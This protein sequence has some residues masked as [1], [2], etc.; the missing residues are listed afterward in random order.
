MSASEIERP[1]SY[2]QEDVQQILQLAMV[3]RQ[4]TN[5]EKLSRQ[6]LLEIAAELEI[7]P[8]SLQLAEQDWLTERTLEKKRAAF[9]AYRRDKLKQKGIRYI[10]VNSFLVTLNLIGSG[11]ISWSLYILLIWGLAL[12]LTTWKTLQTQGE[13]YD[14]AF[15]RWNFNQEMKTSVVSIWGKIKKSLQ[16]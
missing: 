12:S 4:V 16:L 6:Q 10:I 3:S 14:R 13:A 9:N 7:D 8:Q 15:E 11:T 5:D 1:E 2:S